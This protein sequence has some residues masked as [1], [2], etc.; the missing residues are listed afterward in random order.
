MDE[1]KRRSK[2]AELRKIATVRNIRKFEDDVYEYTM[3]IRHISNEEDEVLKSSRLRLLSAINK[4]LKSSLS[5]LGIDTVDK[6]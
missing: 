6:L 2:F 1:T 5:I 4:V 3:R